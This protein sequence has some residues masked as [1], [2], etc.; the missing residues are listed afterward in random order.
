MKGSAWRIKVP[1]GC[2]GRGDDTVNNVLEILG[3]AIPVL[4]L[5]KE[6]SEDG[7]EFPCLLVLGDNTS[8]IAWLHKSGQLARTSQYYPVVKLIARRLAEKVVTAKATL[9]S[10][11]LAGEHNRVADLLS[12]EGVDRGKEE[13]LTI[14]RPPNSILT[15]RVHRFHSQLVPVGFRIHQLP[16]E[17]ESFAFSVIQTVSRLWS[18]KEKPT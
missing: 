17:I 16:T 8:A 1:A 10:Q 18:P 4:I 3:M 11:H 12:F 6:A 7:E 9:C 2:H 5:L 14:D 15:E 13:P